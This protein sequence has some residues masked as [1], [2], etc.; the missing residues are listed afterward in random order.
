MTKRKKI[1]MKTRENP[2]LKPNPTKTRNNQKNKT[3][4]KKTPKRKYQDPQVAI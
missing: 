2:N 1:R 3:Y 4:R